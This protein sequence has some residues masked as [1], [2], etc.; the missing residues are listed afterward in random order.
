MLDKYILSMGAGAGIG[1]VIPKVLEQY[2]EPTYGATIPGLEMLG[3]W[4]KWSVFIPLVAGAGTFLVS[5][6]TNIVANKN[7][8]LNDMLGVFGITSATYGALN[9]VFSMPSGRARARAPAMTMSR[10]RPTLR[11]GNRETFKNNG[12]TPTGISGKTI[13]A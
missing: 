3:N 1:V 11:I 10:P 9:G 8:T 2:V 4:G 5:Q 13:V 12:P 7:K 6:F